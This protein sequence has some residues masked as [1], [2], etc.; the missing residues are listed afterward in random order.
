MQVQGRS[1]MSKIKTAT[2]H[3]AGKVDESQAAAIRFVCIQCDSTN[4]SRNCM[5]SKQRVCLIHGPPGTGKTNTLLHL[6]GV[7]FD[8][9]PS[10]KSSRRKNA[11]S[12]LTGPN[13]FS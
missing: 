13:T 8:S 7:H 11:A 4:E 12:K 6:L 5:V 9:L 10:G 3:L 2:S 1:E